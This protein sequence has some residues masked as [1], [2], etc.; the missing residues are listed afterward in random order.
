[1]ISLDDPANVDLLS[2]CRISEHFNIPL[3]EIWKAAAYDGAFP[4]YRRD[5]RGCR[6]YPLPDLNEYFD[7]ER[8]Q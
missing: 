8:Y 2:V 1:M 5:S 7:G 4:H 6:R 3:S